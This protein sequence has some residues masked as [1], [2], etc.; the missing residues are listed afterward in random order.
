MLCMAAHA[1]AVLRQAADAATQEAALQCVAA[2]VEAILRAGTGDTSSEAFM[3]I[4][5]DLLAE[6]EPRA[7]PEHSSRLAA[8]TALTAC[9]LLDPS[10]MLATHPPSAQTG[11]GASDT[12]PAGAERNES[13]AL[14]LRAWAVAV[15]LL[16]DEDP[17]MRCAAHSVHRCDAHRQAA[18]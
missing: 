12:R 16:E 1:R 11:N 5:S 10:L 13:Q 7:A 8:A 15:T 3:G 14:L 6:I 18:D 9:G 17:D 4:L 2:C